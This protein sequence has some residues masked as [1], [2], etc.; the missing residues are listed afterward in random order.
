MSDPL[1][2][3]RIEHK[4]DLILHAMKHAGIM[5]QDLPQLYEYSGDI[6]PVCASP[7][8]ITLDVM[9]E[10][11][12]RSCSCSPVAQLVRGISSLAT[13]TPVRPPKGH[14][15]DVDVNEPS[16]T[17]RSGSPTVPVLRNR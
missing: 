17:S 1:Q 15:E 9:G 7:I 2:L 5:I 14:V 6:C 10:S 13:P 12:V 8:K 11:Y 16:P 4:L 3:L